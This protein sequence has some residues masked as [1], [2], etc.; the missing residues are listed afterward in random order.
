[1]NI[2][3]AHSRTVK[4]YLLDVKDGEV[5][6]KPHSRSAARYRVT[7]IEVSKRDG[8]VSSVILSGPVLKKDGSVSLVGATERM[9]SRSDW[10]NWLA[11]AVGG[12]A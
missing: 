12:L 1:M 8:N 4:T 6:E 11:S 5:R 9:H 10:P 3:V 7:R 2:T